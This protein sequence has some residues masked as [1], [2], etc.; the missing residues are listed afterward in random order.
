MLA[1][2]GCSEMPPPPWA[3]P[4]ANVLAKCAPLPQFQGTTCDDVITE[5]LG[6]VA[7]YRECSA[8]HDGLVDSQ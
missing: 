3:K 6:L 4:H 1:V 7:L 8:R 5:Y 2:S